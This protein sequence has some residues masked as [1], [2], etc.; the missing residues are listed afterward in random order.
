M[1]NYLIHNKKAFIF[2][3]GIF[4]LIFSLFFISSSVITDA[5]PDYGNNFS[6]SIVFAGIPAVVVFLIVRMF[7]GDNH[8]EVTSVRPNESSIVGIELRDPEFHRGALR[9]FLIPALWAVLFYN[10]VG[11]SIFLKLVVLSFSLALWPPFAAPFVIGVIH[12]Y[13]SGKRSLAV[14]YVCGGI[15]GIIFAYFWYMI[16][17]LGLRI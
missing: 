3:G 17:F 16:M 12:Y 10:S 11:A 7:I 6:V 14:G 4:T 5:P 2:A 1:L 8:D 15:A 13:K 9:G